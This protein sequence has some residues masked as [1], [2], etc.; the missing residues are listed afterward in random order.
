[1]TGKPCLST[2]PQRRARR[3]AKC[4]RQLNRCRP[5]GGG[6]SEGTAGSAELPAERGG[7]R[8]IEE[9]ANEVALEAGQKEKGQITESVDSGFTC[10]LDIGFANGARLPL[11]IPRGH[12]VCQAPSTQQK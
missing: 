7:G 3:S 10:Q 9:R 2:G 6:D 12:A 1:M 5:S 8:K 11:G 4:H